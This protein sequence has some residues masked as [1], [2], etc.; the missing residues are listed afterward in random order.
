MGAKNV[1]DLCGCGELKTRVALTCLACRTASRQPPPGLKHG[2]IRCACGKGK[3]W[4]ANRCRACDTVFRT[5]PLLERLA[6]ARHKRELDAENKR[7]LRAAWT[8]EQWAAHRAAVK[9]N[10]AK[11]TP[12]QIATKK[13]RNTELRK[14][15]RFKTETYAEL[16]AKKV[17]DGTWETWVQ[18]QRDRSNRY[19]ATERGKVL[20][21]IRAQVYRENGTAYAHRR[22]YTLKRY[23]LNHEQFQQLVVGFGGC[24]MCGAREPPNAHGWCVDHCH[25]T[26]IIRGLL[27]SPCNVTLGL[28]GDNTAGARKLL[29]M[30]ERYEV[31]GPSRVEFILGFQPVYVA[32]VPRIK[33]PKSRKP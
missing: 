31:D 17:A 3:T 2:Q 30:V 1:K 15:G 19:K 18:E 11:F 26:G 5:A 6:K 12:E 24:G 8:E 29:E 25:T 27:C 13:A 21:T 9:A 23:G 32:P 10:A 28:I 16:K 33:G 20:A 7:A 22:T 14:A 4:K